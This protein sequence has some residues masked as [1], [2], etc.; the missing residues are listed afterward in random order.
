M[1]L[2]SRGGGLSHEG[3]KKYNQHYHHALDVVVNNNMLASELESDDSVVSQRLEEALREFCR[4]NCKELYSLAYFSLHPWFERAWVIQEVVLATASNVIVHW[5]AGICT[6]LE[7]IN[8]F[9][10]LVSLYIRITMAKGSY[11]TVAARLVRTTVERLEMTISQSLKLPKTK[12]L[13]T[14]INDLLIRG[15]T[16]ATQPEDLVYSLMGLASDGDTCGIEIEYDKHYTKVFREVA[17]LLLKTLGPQTLAW[18]GQQKRDT[19]ADGCRLPSWVPDLRLNAPNRIFS[20]I[21]PVPKLFSASGSRNFEYTVGENSKILSVRTSYVDRVIEASRSFQGPAWDL[22]S[23]FDV[24]SQEQA[25]L[26]DFGRVLDVAADRHPSRYDYSTRQ[27]MRWRMPIADRYSDAHTRSLRRAGPEIKDWYNA[28]MRPGDPSYASV[29][30][31]RW[32]TQGFTYLQAQAPFVTETGY[33]GIGREG[34]VEGDELHLV[35]GSETPFIL[36]KT[37]GRYELVCETYVHGIMDGEL[38]DDNTE[39]EWLQIH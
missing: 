38:V 32:L 24:L 17:I 19:N 36:R 22:D 20:N 31:N 23:A 5:E 2:G 7:I 10:L 29:P 4:N 9:M 30:S 3:V 34:I 21:L 16:R 39:F 12:S 13:I 11:P 33:I 8:I 28:M 6:W 27:E 18:S 1:W 25:R 35:Q 15:Q 37:D 26:K 14:L